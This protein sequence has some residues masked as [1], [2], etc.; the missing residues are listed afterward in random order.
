MTPTVVALR[1]MATSVVDAEMERL[2]H[3]LPGL[4]EADRAEVLRTVR[5]VADKLLH[6]PT[7][8]GARAR[9]RGRCGVLRRGA[10]ELFALDPD[11]VEAVTPARG[12]DVSATRTSTVPGTVASAPA[13]PCSPPP[14]PRWWRA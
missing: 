14:S 3:R 11:A 4:S 10:A 1:S 6:E 2:D 13:P 8:R 5:R 12:A 9:Q 7:V